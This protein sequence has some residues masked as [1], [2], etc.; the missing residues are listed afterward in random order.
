MLSLFRKGGLF[1]QIFM[2]AVV[3]AICAAFIFTGQFGSAGSADRCA[4]KLGATCVDL[5]EFNAG[6][7]LAVR[8]SGLELT[9]EGAREIKG[10]I[11]NGF[12]ERILLLEEAER[13]GITVSEEDLD[14][15]LREGR[16]RLSL[17]A[18]HETQLS[19]QLRLCKPEGPTCAP[20]TE[21][22][23]MLPVETEGAFNNDLYRRMVRNY[24]GRGPK[25]FKAMQRD[26][27]VAARMRR[28]IRSRV[29]VSEDEAFLLWERE[30]S[31]ATI[32]SVEARSEWMARYVLNLTGADVDEWAMNNKEAI[33]SRL[34]QEK[35]HFSDGC[36][37]VQEIF[38]RVMPDA[39]DEEKAAKRTEIEEAQRR[40]KNN[41]SVEL[42]A[43]EL[44][45]ADTAQTGGALGCL[46][47]HYGPGAQV[48]MQAASKLAPGKVS[49]IVESVRGFHLLK[50]TQ[51]L[52]QGQ[53]EAT[54]R[55]HI[56]RELATAAKGKELA[57]KFAKELLTKVKEN[58]SLKDATEALVVEYATRGPLAGKRDAEAPGLGD[59]GR[60]K[61][62]ISSPFNVLQ[63]PIRNAVQRDVASLA[64]ELKK[65]D[66]YYEKPIETS[67]GYAV[68]QLKSKEAAKRAE[69][70][71]D[72]A[73]L[74]R[75]LGQVKA[76]EALE[77]HLEMLRKAAGD[78]LTFDKELVNSTKAK[79]EEESESDES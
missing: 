44:S 75:Q 52:A 32:R 73:K 45:D 24:S 26:E 15:E 56:A 79:D 33:D 77:T 13:L 22:I 60:P 78:E 58:P 74:L 72:K 7:G 38:V 6:Y 41:E 48:L 71:K 29:R 59:D 3:V 57:E 43:R 55:L 2:G 9:P 30:R 10:M 64:F 46:G 42:L 25:Q 40:L 18:A 66:D 5:K 36:P 76:T 37:M 39:S 53:A 12:A 50:L 70:E 21:G 16:T 65:P 23:R 11:L 69:F 67:G 61:V 27:I 51:N 62:A 1:S 54:A 34:A 19:A 35:D 14:N 17:P 63:G 31:Q 68:F 28:L 8:A 47:E 4:V 49:P 20:G